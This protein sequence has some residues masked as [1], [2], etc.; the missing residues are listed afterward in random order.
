MASNCTVSLP[1]LSFILRV[2]SLYALFL[3][4]EAHF[5]LWRRLF[6]LVPRNQRGSIVEVGEAEVWRITGTGYLSSMPK[7]ESEEWPSEW[8]YIEDAPLLEPVRIGLLEISSAPLKK[9]H[10]WRPQSL[11]EEDS[12]QVRQLISKIKMLTR[13][14][15]SI[16][17]VM[18]TSI[19]RGVQP[20]QYRG[21]PMW[22]YNG[23]DNA[24]YCGRKG[25]DTPR[26][27]GQNTGQTIQRGVSVSKPVYL[28]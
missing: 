19:V 14:R 20:L 15:L 7:K 9:R 18:A 27:F 24:T 13:S 11:R 6:Y 5:D 21:H 1:P 12:L 17:E 3:G 2:M 25:P 26:R 22:H 23:E 10:S 28:G 16:V 8:F 4:Y